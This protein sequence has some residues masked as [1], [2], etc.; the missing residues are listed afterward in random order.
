MFRRF[1]GAIIAGAPERSGT[2]IGSPQVEPALGGRIVLGEESLRERTARG[3][4]INGAYLV[5][6]YSLSLLRGF[7]VAAFLTLGEYGVWGV[8]AIA[9]GTILQLKQVGIGDKYIQ[10]S[11]RGQE[12]AFQKAFTLELMATGLVSVLLLLVLPLLALAYGRSRLIAPGAVLALAPLGAALQA[13]VWIFYRRMDFVRQRR[14]QAVDPAVAFA[15]TVGLAVAGAGYWSLVVGTVAG[16]W[17]GGF[18]ALRASPYR[19]ALRYDG[20]TM[21]EYAAFSWP[22]FVAGMTPVAMAQVAALTGARVLGLA[23]VGVIVLAGSISDYTNRV[24]AIVTETLYPSI[25]AVRD[26]ADLMLESFV[27]SNRLALMWGVP[28][29]IGLALFAPDLVNLGIGGRWRSGIH[30][31]QA[32]GAIAALNHIGFNW[33]AFFRAHGR[34]RPIAVWSLIVLISFLACPLPLLIWEGLNGFAIG[35]AA[36]TIVSLLVRAVYLKRLLTGLQVLRHTA[37]AIMPVVPAVLV[38]LAARA[39]EPTHRGIAAAVIEFVAYLAVTVVAT[40]GFERALL[41]EVAG[42]LRR[43]GSGRAQVATS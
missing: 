37:R 14:L 5:G 26:R 21:R 10:Q 32:F 40:L 20:G 9:L 7:I 29:G 30:L 4:V 36:V 33:D 39:I 41:R 15:L 27:K 25:C 19:L 17:S 8:L 31:I 28:F 6:F 13:P 12:E 2:P 18:V 34:T 11:E 24:D 42:Y 35:M 3:A 43:S 1:H 22:L 23:A 38:V 16:A